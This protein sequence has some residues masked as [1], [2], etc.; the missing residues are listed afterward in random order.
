M[1]WNEAA[2]LLCPL[3][4]S[5]PV[6]AFASTHSV[7]ATLS[8]GLIISIF[9]SWLKCLI[10]YSFYFSMVGQFVVACGYIF[11]RS[12]VTKTSSM[13][14]STENRPLS[15]AILFVALQSFGLISLFLPTLALNKS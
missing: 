2:F 5:L 13:W 11:F 8:V 6:G 3:F 4:F 1:F 14:F 12:A 9:G 7:K 10:N 15:T